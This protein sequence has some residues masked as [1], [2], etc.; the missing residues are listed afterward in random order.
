MRLFAVAVLFFLLPWIMPALAEEDGA[1][2]FVPGPLDRELEEQALQSLLEETAFTVSDPKEEVEVDPQLTRFW[3]GYKPDW[4]VKVK[5]VKLT[6]TREAAP[7]EEGLHSFTATL[8]FDSDGMVFLTDRPR[9]RKYVGGI[10]LEITPQRGW[11]MAFDGQGDT[12]AGLALARRG[13]PGLAAALVCPLFSAAD[14]AA[15]DSTALPEFQL[16]AAEFVVSG[17][18]QGRVQSGV[19]VGLA[20]SA[21]FTTPNIRRARPAVD[22]VVAKDPEASIEYTA[23]PA[24]E[25]VVEPFNGETAG[26]VR[27]LLEL[28]NA[29][30]Y[31]RSGELEQVAWV[32]RV[33]PA[34]SF[35]ARSLG[36]GTV[37][38]P[39][40]QCALVVIKETQR[41]IYSKEE[42]QAPEASQ[43]AG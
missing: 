43:A 3:R 25:L 7:E 36:G 5:E 22:E 41:V 15:D 28:Q 40:D 6:F 4:S 31:K 29:A 21:V 32:K 1:G 8:K 39:A 24:E 42:L 23:D 34:R 35:T 13:S 33:T 37:T 18:A 38:V 27:V 10:R 26:G 30:G 2:H 17:F 11:K 20:R 9:Y 16:Q 12:S 14:S 19:G